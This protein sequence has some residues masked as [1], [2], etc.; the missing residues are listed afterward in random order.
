M[1][2]RS[3]GS[4]N[5]RVPGG[6]C[7]YHRGMVILLSLLCAFG[8][9]QAQNTSL[10]LPKA[11]PVYAQPKSEARLLFM[12]KEG[13]RV[14]VRKK[15]PRY[16]SVEIRRGGQ[17][18]TGF[19]LNSDLVRE[20][21][22]GRPRGD[23]GM[24]GGGLY[25]YFRHAGKS[26]E[27]DDQV[28]YTTT[29]FT[30]TAASP[31]VLIQF[32][33]EDFWRLILTYRRT[34]FESSASTNV[35]GARPRELRLQHTMFSAIIQKMWTPL[36]SKNWYSGLG[37]EVSR[38]TEAHL[39]LGANQLPVASE[40]LPTYFGGHLAMGAQLDL[41]WRL[42]LFTE[43][44]VTGYFNQDPMVFGAEVGAGLIYWP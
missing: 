4:Q 33:H 37:V 29:E 15:G 17:W 12:A 26:F 24:G 13:E 8:L 41:R 2:H 43:L 20:T 21:S 23:F 40:D 27:T 6:I 31:F 35:P 30:S 36:K 44:R 1:A 5:A 42:S 14:V 32:F 18:K 25:S 16:S 3:Q 7:P 19:I 22:W 11:A 10:L 34:D 28:Q 9:A 38:A 39:V